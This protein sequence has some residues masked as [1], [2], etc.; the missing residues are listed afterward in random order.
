M[1][2]THAGL[3]VDLELKIE[4]KIEIHCK[5]GHDHSADLSCES[6]QRVPPPQPAS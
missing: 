4:L 3:S 5:D 2:H 1:C 6:R